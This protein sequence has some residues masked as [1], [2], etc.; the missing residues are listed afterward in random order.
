M[1]LFVLL[2]THLMHASDQ[3]ELI[4]KISKTTWDAADPNIKQELLA[5]TSLVKNQQQLIT[6]L[7]QEI[8]KNSAFN[9]ALEYVVNPDCRNDRK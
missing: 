6:Q 3:D 1:F 7:K 9:A 5:L 4:T 2:C 8:D